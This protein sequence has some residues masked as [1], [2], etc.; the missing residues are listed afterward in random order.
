MLSIEFNTKLL[1]LHFQWPDR[2]SQTVSSEEA[3]EFFKWLILDHG[4]LPEVDALAGVEDV[5][6]FLQKNIKV[7]QDNADKE[8]AKPYNARTEP[9]IENDVEVMLSVDECAENS[10][11]VGMT[12]NGR[13]L[14]LGLHGMTVIVD[15]NIPQ[16]TILSL[17][18]RTEDGDSFELLGQAKWTRPTEEGQLMG[19]KL[20]ESKGFENW[21]D[22]FGLKFVAPKIGRNYKPKS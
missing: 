22:Q 3:M 7:L 9:R 18:L 1:K 20:M 16:G 15:E 4:D 12:S 14:D 13:T 10:D 6:L 11:L 2:E 8:P 21:R 5:E 19:I 17:Y